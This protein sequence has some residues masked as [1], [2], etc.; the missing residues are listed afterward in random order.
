MTLSSKAIKDILV[1][2]MNFDGLIFTDGLGMKGV[3]KH[4]AVGELEVKALQAGNDILLL[5]ENTPAAYKKIKAAYENGTLDSLDIHRKVKKILRAK[6]DLGLTSF[7][8]LSQFGVRAD[9][10]NAQAMMM[11]RKLVE[12]ALTLVRNKNNALPIKNVDTQKTASLA[13]GTGRETTFQKYLKKYDGVYNLQS[14]WSIPSS[15]PL[16]AKL[17]NYDKVVVSLH[18][19]SSRSSKN[20]G[21]TD[22]AIRFISQ[23]QNETEV[24]LVVFG[25]P[26]SLKYFDGVETILQCY[27]ENDMVESVAAQAVFGAIPIEGKLPITASPKSKFNDGESTVSLN[28][29]LYDRPESVG[30]N[31]FKLLKID[32][33]A[34]Q[35]ISQR[36]TP[37]LQ[38]MV[39]KNGKAIFHK[40]YG[41]HTYSKKRKVKTDDI[42]DVASVTKVAASTLSVMKLHDDGKINVEESLGKHLTYAKGSDKSSLKIKDIMAHR[43]KLK[44]WIPF[45][46]ETMNESK[47]NPRP[48]TKFY[49]KEPTLTHQVPVTDKLFMK[50]TY[51]QEMWKKIW[52]SELRTNSGYKY[53]DLGFY[54]MAEM[55]KQKSGKSLDDYAMLNFYKPMGLSRSSFNPLNQFTT[56][57]IIPSENDK[58][59]R[60]QKV[61]GHVHDMGAAML[62]GVSGHAGLFASANDLGIIFQMLLNGGNYGGKQYLQA[63]TVNMF[64]NRHP[65]CTRRGIGFDMKQLDGAKSQNVCS[66]ASANTFGHLGFTGTAVWVDK[67]ED[68]IYIFLS[69]RTYPSMNNYKLNKL[70]IRP[71]I[72]S[73]IYDAIE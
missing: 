24:V 23:L 36:A 13:I 53:S 59:F 2:E 64:T 8:P 65:S 38:V 20:F 12:K 70:D 18:N 1:D 46:K 50:N 5:P 55:V 68:L 3:T 29:L 15:I 67:D 17:K 28:R 71:R 14:G 16:M 19:M 45:Y 27:E 35:A 43:A 63:S 11:K 44:A 31:P 30:V 72:Q 10:T 26:Y 61:H 66:E 39:I 48:L 56:S 33:I 32:T 42:Y 4:H 22:A 54:M 21:V 40:A 58:Y 7:T 69:N 52:E 25:N 57:E 51:I 34:Q 73:A 49:K 37:G 6:Y 9:V 62:G 60:R 41:Y 47:S